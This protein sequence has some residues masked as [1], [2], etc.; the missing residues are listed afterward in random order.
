MTSGATLTAFLDAYMAE[1]T[2]R[3]ERFRQ[4]LVEM[5]EHITEL[6]RERTVSLAYLEIGDAGDSL[7]ATVKRNMDKVWFQYVGVG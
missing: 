1:V 5:S 7:Q 3:T 4:R 6:E 2:C